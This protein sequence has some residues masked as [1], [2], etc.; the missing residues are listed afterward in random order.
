MQKLSLSRA[1]AEERLAAAGGSLTHALHS[2][3]QAADGI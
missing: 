3:T 1:T 2:A